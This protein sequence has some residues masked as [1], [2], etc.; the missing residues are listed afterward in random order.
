MNV[1]DMRLRPPLPSL[2]R[3]VLYREQEGV[4]QT[5][6]DDLPRPQSAREGSA[7]LLIREMDE[8]GVRFGVIPG[9]HSAEPFGVIANDEIDQFIARFPGRFV[10][11]AGID[12]RGDA[13]S[14][15]AQIDRWM[16]VEG[17]KGVSIEPSI[18]LT[19]DIR[20]ADDRRLYPIYEECVRRDIP[21]NISISALLQRITKRPYEYSDPRQVYQVA[22]DFPKLDIHVA[23]AGY[24]W[25]MEMIGVAFVCAN[26]W[27]STDT[28][29]IP[30]MPG[31]S[32]YAVAA[33]NLIQDRTLFGSN[34]P[35]KPFRGMIE[36]YSSFGWR[37]GVLE[38]VLGGNALRL[39]RM[40]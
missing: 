23:H 19:D 21:I 14:W 30:Q 24:P 17:F 1:I 11:F 25:V 34:Y 20:R 15:L 12:L 18:S 36:A 4:R 32:E 26:V 27:M 39:L 7:E 2:L 29:L 37:P 22:L 31:A 8:A 33:N 10:A 16:S 38:K 9:R 6:L 35:A 3:S 40:D 28:Y 5:R 13:S